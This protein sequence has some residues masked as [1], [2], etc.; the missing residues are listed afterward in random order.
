MYNSFYEIKRPESFHF[1]GS[2][3]YGP[4]GIGIHLIE[5]NP[6]PKP[7]TINPLSDHMSFQSD[8]LNAVMTHLESLNINYIQQKVFEAGI[9][10][11]QIFFHDPDNNMVEVCNCDSLPICP[12]DNMNNNNAGS[13]T[14]S[15]NNIQI[16]DVRNSFESS[17]SQQI[18]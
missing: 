15:G 4:H 16:I 6:L 2:W 8:N 5:G 13:S 14:D 12:L 10:V 9:E 18:F 17:N 1:D 7:S 3:L 11:A